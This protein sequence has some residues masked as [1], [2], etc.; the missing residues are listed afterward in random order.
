[1]SERFDPIALLK[2]L[3]DHGVEYV[4]IGGVAASALGSPMVTFDLDIC[5]ARHEV[6]LGRLAAALKKVNARLP[7]APDDVPFLLNVE[8]LMR[9]DHLTF[10]TDLGPLDILGTPAGTKGFDEL[11]PNAV[12][13]DLDG[14][15]VLVTGLEDLIRMKHAAG[16]PK[17]RIA[18]EN[19][20]ALR[21]ELEGR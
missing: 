14:V 20:G 12:A 1:M 18:L 7:G 5:Y 2:L 19:L 9:G 4:V 21:D 8:T 13:I 15:R 3:D 10:F 16:R 6:N 11:A 17:D